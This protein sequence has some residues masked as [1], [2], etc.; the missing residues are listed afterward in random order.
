MPVGAAF[1]IDYPDT[2]Q[3]LPTGLTTSLVYYKNVAYPQG[4]YIDSSNRT[5]QIRRGLPIFIPAGSQLK[6]VFGPIINPIHQNMPNTSFNITSY[7]DTTYM[8]SID[9]VDHDLVPTYTCN[10][11]CR[12]C[13]SRQQPDVCLKCY[14]PN[15]VI[16]PAR[17][18]T[19]NYLNGTKCL[20]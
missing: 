3:T 9:K 4:W 19:V 16:D 17:N 13:P 5:I 2:V 20:A 1:I 14:T 8:Y 18:V 15:D 10:F 12:R 7:T 11:P 6:V